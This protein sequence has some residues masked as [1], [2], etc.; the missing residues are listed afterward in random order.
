MKEKCPSATINLNPSLELILFWPCYGNVL[1]TSALFLLSQTYFSHYLKFPGS[2]YTFLLGPFVIFVLA[3]LLCVWFKVSVSAGYSNKHI[4]FTHNCIYGGAGHPL[5]L[6]IWT[7][8]DSLC[9]ILLCVHV[10]TN[11][12]HLGLNSQGRILW[13]WDK[14]STQPDR[15]LEFSCTTAKYDMLEKQSKG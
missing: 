5:T 10:I 1:H 15:G 8:C 4:G 3:D 11:P 13:G 12:S 2:H 14:H 9:L 6:C 7:C